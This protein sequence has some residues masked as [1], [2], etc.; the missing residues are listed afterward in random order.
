[1][2]LSLINIFP[3]SDVTLILLV[4]KL[5]IVALSAVCRIVISDDIV[6]SPINATSAFNIFVK[7]SSAVN[8]PTKIFFNVALSPL[9]FLIVADSINALSAVKSPINDFVTF[10]KSI[11]ASTICAPVNVES[12]IFEPVIVPSSNLLL[13]IVESF[14]FSPV[15]APSFMRIPNCVPIEL[16]IDCAIVPLL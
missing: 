4:N 9:R 10:S 3:L 8:S 7:I 1:M 5:S 15:I 12:A 13:V 2:V 14:I 16:P 11:V 6:P